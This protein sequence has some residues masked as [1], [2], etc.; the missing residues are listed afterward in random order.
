MDDLALETRDGL[1]EALQV[2]LDSYPRTGWTRDPG[3]DGLIRFW[4][5]RHMMFRRLMD[6]MQ[7]NTDALLDRKR[8]A[9]AFA[10]GVARYGGMFV[11]GLHEHHMIEDAH[12]FPRLVLK[13]PRIARGFEMLDADH[14]ALDGHLNAFA[15][16]ANAT[17]RVRDDR[18]RLQDEAGRFRSSLGDMARL[19][20]RHLTDEEDLIVPV[21][22]KFGSA[23]LG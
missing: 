13:D 11:N 18:D 8:E 17:L 12:Y 22:L 6:E 14:H 2:L 15:D 7:S 9:G 19:L 10:Q 20:D 1:P 5:D 23:D 3:F 4:L 21:I 16:D